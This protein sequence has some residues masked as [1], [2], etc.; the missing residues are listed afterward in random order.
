MSH[1][2]KKYF[3]WQREQGVFGGVVDLFKFEKYIN[4][5]DRVIDFGCGGGYL[6]LNINCQEKLGIEINEYA[7]DDAKTN[8]IAAVKSTSELEDNWA[9]VIISNHALEHVPN[10]YEELKTLYKK[11]KVGGKIIIVVPHERKGAYNE[12]DINKHLYTWS[13]SNLGNLFVTAGFHVEQVET[14]FHT[15]PPYYYLIK[16]MFG[17]TLFHKICNI[18]GRLVSNRQVRVIAVK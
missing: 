15:W 5:S 14:L 12:N 16:K 6:L 2:N 8:G 9:D 11:L 13:P 18:Y 3:D 17:L 7:R 1:Y 10:P 4:T